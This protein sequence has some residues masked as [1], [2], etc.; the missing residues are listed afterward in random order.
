M[1]DKIKVAVVDDSLFVRT[2]LSDMLSTDPEIEVV[3]TAKDGQDAIELVRKEKPNIVT[4]DLVMPRLDGLQALEKITQT[5]PNTSVIMLSAAD[6]ASAD[7]IMR[8]LDLGAFDFVM[9][10]ASTSSTD[11]LRLKWEIITKIKLAFKSGGKRILEKEEILSLPARKVD[12]KCP[13]GKKGPLV[14]IGASTGGPV[15][16]RY[17]LGSMPPKLPAPIVIAQHMP[18]AFTESFSERLSKMCKIP[19]IEA[20][21]GM[22]LSPCHAYI[23]P[24]ERH[25]EVVESG[26]KLEIRLSEG[27]RLRGGRPSVDLLFSSVADA[28]GKNAIGVILTGMGSDGA[29]GIKRIREV[30]GKTIAQDEETSLVWSMPHAAIRLGVV[31]EVLPLKD[32]P[33]AIL[34]G[35]GG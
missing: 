8:S 20:K 10:P 5:E 13:S 18:K 2:I 35:V 19:V 6:R 23:A 26:G 21:E 7:A 15:A 17:I 28:V 29:R 3:G 33:K 31:D 9:K 16:L 1:V 24:G 4:M 11:I 30:G 34:A 32:I 27:E 12:A 25:M 22:V 14:A